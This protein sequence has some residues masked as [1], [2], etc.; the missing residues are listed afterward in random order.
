MRFVH[1]ALGLFLLA[2]TAVT[3]FVGCAA[4]QTIDKFGA[5]AD[6]LNAALRTV[7]APKWGMLA[8][9]DTTLFQSRLT[10]DAVNKVAIHEQHQ[11]NT[12]DAYGA[13]LFTDFHGLAGK[14]GIAVDTVTG[15]A[16]AA[17]GALKQA[18]TDLGTL[19]GAIAATQPL[20]GAYTASGLDLD[21]LLKDQ[22]IHRTIG[23][24]DRLSL[25]MAGTTENVQGMTGD[26]KRVSDD[27]TEK[28]F[29]PQ[30]WW[31]KVGPVAFDGTKI[32]VSLGCLIT[33]SC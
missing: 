3:V 15:T 14:G 26:G 1:T 31:R 18:Q 27:L 32:G 9:V 7:N 28:Y 17:T 33:R 30:P 8:A 5:A 2:L 13:Q 11:L 10:I 20:L 29:T 23:N 12:Y 22:S 6:G 21:A 4:Y 16:K 24:L 25:A 19:D